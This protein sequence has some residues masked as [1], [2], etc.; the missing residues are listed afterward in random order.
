MKNSVWG[1]LKKCC[2]FTLVEILTGVMIGVVVFGAVVMLMGQ[3]LNVVGANVAY[4][5]AQR[6]VLSVNEFLPKDIAYAGAVEILV[7]PHDITDDLLNEE[8]HYIVRKDDKVRHL[9]WSDGRR[10]D[11]IPGSEFITNLS[12]DATVFSP[13]FPGGRA[14]RVFVEAEYNEKKVS[15]NRSRLV[16]APGGVTGKDNAPV[17][18]AFPGG[19]ILRFRMAS[20][21]PPLEVHIF[22]SWNTG[23]EQVC[24]DYASP[25]TWKSTRECGIVTRLDAALR[26]S[27]QMYK[28]VDVDEPPLYTWIAV[29]P[30]V[31]FSAGE[32]LKGSAFA[33]LSQMGKQKALLDVLRKRLPQVEEGTK[34]PGIKTTPQELM[35]D[36]F[37]TAL[38]PSA[39]GYG[40]RILEIS[41]GERLR[42]SD[43]SGKLEDPFD[44][45]G[46]VNT[47]LREPGEYQ[48]VPIIVAAHYKLQDGT[49]EI[50]PAFAKLGENS[51]GTLWERVMRTV[52]EGT[53]VGRGEYKNENAGLSKLVPNKDNTFTAFGTT[54]SR[55]RG[56]QI[57]LELTD[58]DFKHL[59]TETGVCGV[60]NYTLYME[61]QMTYSGTLGGQN[62]IDGGYGVLLNGSAAQTAKLPTGPENLSSGYIFQIDP[63]AG[64][65]LFRHAYYKNIPLSA[66]QL[67]LSDSKNPRINLYDHDASVSFG[68]HP[69]YVYDASKSTH[70]RPRTLEAARKVNF[71]TTPDPSNPTIFTENFNENAGIV[72]ANQRV[73]YRLPFFPEGYFNTS[74]SGN[75]HGSHSAYDGILAVAGT[76]SASGYSGANDTNGVN[77]FYPYYTLKYTQGTFT[78]GRNKIGLSHYLEYGGPYGMTFGGGNRSV[79]N[80]KLMQTWHFY[81][82][83][84]DVGPN[85]KPLTK[86]DIQ[87]RDAVDT[88]RGFRWDLDR[89]DTQWRSVPRG[90]STRHIIRLTVLEITR[91][92]HAWEV[93]KEWRPRIHHVSSTDSDYPWNNPDCY[94]NDDV[95]HKAGDM[96]V[97][98]EMIQLKKLNPGNGDVDIRD[99][100]NYV[101]SKPIWFGKFRGDSWKG[102]APSLF[103]KMGNRMMHLVSEP[104]PKGGDA[105]TFRGRGMRIRSWKDNFRG[106]DFD[107]P[108]YDSRD[109]TW[110]NDLIGKNYGLTPFHPDMEGGESGGD[111]VVW[112]PP[113]AIDL[114]GYGVHGDWGE[115]N[116]MFLL[117]TLQNPRHELFGYR[118]VNSEG[119]TVGGYYLSGGPSLNAAINARANVGFT[120]DVHSVYQYGDRRGDTYGNY[121]FTGEKVE[122]ER[123]L[124]NPGSPPAKPGPD[125]YVYAYNGKYTPMIYGRL[126][127]QRPW[128]MRNTPIYGLYAL[129][130]WDYTLFERIGGGSDTSILGENP[131]NPVYD[132]NKFSWREENS[133]ENIERNDQGFATKRFLMVVQGLQMPYQPNRIKALDDLLPYTSATPG[134]AIRNGVFT[135]EP[136]KIVPAEKASDLG[137]LS[138]EHEY[139]YRRTPAGSPDQAYKPDRRRMLGFR[140]WAG[141]S[142]GNDTSKHNDAWVTGAQN[143]NQFK[144]YDMW[145][146]AGF[147]PGEVRRILGL[148]PSRYPDN[149]PNLGEKIAEFYKTKP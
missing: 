69:L 93:E 65:F 1:R 70:T 129:R 107:K 103:K 83:P 45:G 74:N 120:N 30:D 19:P 96:F 137:G 79:Y 108:N 76:A 52:T 60:T 124:K 131:Y 15:L 75:Y 39:A 90:W 140:F 88:R 95:I 57:L 130:N 53:N 92:I 58:D 36:P 28:K 144:F 33:A 139:Y 29:S 142:S 80:P 62:R 23:S 126:S 73:Y 138:S 78:E 54:T 86:P 148:D 119:R 16:R 147:S 136:K 12:F 21:E 17:D 101:Y 97:R 49:W 46:I 105:Q 72:N 26:L 85:E 24:F 66:A 55:Q 71:F 2:G 145:F 104:E 56:P 42:Q 4:S 7:P 13:D 8:W 132:F 89:D 44:I 98:M 9:Y 64:G 122:F 40:F 43:R 14:L 10:D 25:D 128:E 112:T 3:G 118:S 67:D 6:A 100:R 117:E 141:D 50:M 5:V 51:G 99:S 84:T 27:E 77:N 143:P 146:D 47:M 20:E 94:E 59:G 82:N 91:D 113:V 41:Q 32:K 87:V 149:D 18:A 61:G 37:N 127:M 111:E 22:G 109:Y 121:A 34:S 116:D 110:V 123:R 106:W 35:E 38:S 102:D 68:V 135:A 133:H 11:P 31:L 48:G 115:R 81:Y 134:A 114:K 125:D 63:G